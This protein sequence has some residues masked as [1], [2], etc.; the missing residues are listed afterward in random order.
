MVNAT[1]STT[2]LGAFDPVDEIADICEK[3]GIWLHIDAAIGG[4][5]LFSELKRH[6]RTGIDRADSLAWDPH[7]H[8]VV[9]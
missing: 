4:T 9:P 2:V 7:K 5:V 3:Y 8:L 1:C 6:L